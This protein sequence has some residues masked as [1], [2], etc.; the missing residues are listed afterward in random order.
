MTKQAVG[1]VSLGVD[2]SFKSLTLHYYPPFQSHSTESPVSAQRQGFLNMNW[3]NAKVI[4]SGLL[5]TMLKEKKAVLRNAAF[6][7]PKF[8][9]MLHDN[10]AISQYR[11]EDLEDYIEGLSTFLVYPVFDNFSEDQQVAGVLATN[12]YW[13]I[14]FSHLLP[15]SSQGIICVV[16]NS[17]NQTFA[18]RID[19]PE[20]NFLGPGDPHDPKYDDLELSENVNDYLQRRASPRNRAYATVPV[21]DTTQYTIRVY[22]SQDTE[23]QFVTNKPIFYTMAV[24]FGF[25]L[26]SILFLLFSYVVEKRQHIMIAKVVENAERVANTERELNEFLAHEVSTSFRSLKPYLC[27]DT[28]SSTTV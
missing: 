28:I 13:K 1:Y 8:L 25:A 2:C 19:G 27:G 11:G 18:Y 14:L 26:A 21:S 16:E 22:P 23:D 3:V 20:A 9:K 4:G 10:L 12:V 15:S 17:F 6:P 5:G 24:I 7:I